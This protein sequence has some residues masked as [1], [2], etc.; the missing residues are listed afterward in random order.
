MNDQGAISGLIVVLIIVATGAAVGALYVLAGPETDLTDGDNGSQPVEGRIT[1]AYPPA[2][3]GNVAFIKPMG[4][5]TGSHVTPI[6]H[7]YYL[8]SDH[9]EGWGASILVDVYS[10][11]DGTVTSIQHMGSLPGLDNI[12]ID[13]YRLVIQHTDTVSSVFIHIDHVSEKIA[14]AAPPLG[15][16]ASVS[17]DVS[18]GEVIGA[19]TGSLDYNV[20]DED[21]VLTGFARPESYNEE[22]KTH[23]PDPFDYF[24][25]PLRSE[26]RAKCLRSAKPVGGK[27]D[28]D[29]DGR[30]VGNW[31]KEGTNGYAGLDQNWYWVGHLSVVYDSIDPEHIV[32]STGDYGGESRKFGV[33]GNAPDPADVGTG[34]G[35]VEYELTD[36]EYYDGDSHWDRESLVKGLDAR[37]S[38]HV[39]GVVLFELVE[40]QRLKVEIFDGATASEVTGFTGNAIFYER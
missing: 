33:A 22:W 31:F 19:Y 8:A 4:G 6:D 11:A 30:L 40:D 37:N 1:F 18:A 14:A 5:I 16:Y 34:T 9:M 21:V 26:L 7:Q 23:I 13:D 20:I 38:E 28:Y 15:E 24:D 36:F 2:D 10:P 12:Q 39:S 29:I 25:E 17:V 27:I 32:V 35:I 3:M